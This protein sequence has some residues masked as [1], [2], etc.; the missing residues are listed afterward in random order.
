MH[1]EG[2]IKFNYFVDRN[3]S[4]NNPTKKLPRALFLLLAEIPENAHNSTLF[5]LS[6]VRD[7][8]ALRVN[9]QADQAG[10]GELEKWEAVR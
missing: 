10:Q 6:P 7:T 4:R 1:T 5:W 2:A 3:Q 9:K 8:E